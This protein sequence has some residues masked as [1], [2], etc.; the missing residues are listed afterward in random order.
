MELTGYERLK[1]LM[2]TSAGGSSAAARITM[3]PTM[4]PRRLADCKSTPT[5]GMLQQQSTQSD[6]LRWGLQAQR[7]LKSRGHHVT[8]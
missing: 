8:T 2:A 4:P 1:S 5:P 7:W 6:S 3:S